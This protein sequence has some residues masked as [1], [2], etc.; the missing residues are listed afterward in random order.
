RIQIPPGP[1]L[2]EIVMEARGLGKGYDGRL[3]IDGLDFLMPR[4][5][6]VGVIGANGAGK[7]TLIRMITG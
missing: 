1:R 2:G 5:A 7:T 4:G 3:L 6:I